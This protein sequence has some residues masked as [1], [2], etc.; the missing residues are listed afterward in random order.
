MNLLQI[1]NRPP[2]VARTKY[3]RK[4]TLKLFFNLFALG[5]VIVSIAAA[6]SYITPTLEGYGIPANIAP[7]IGY[8]IG[9]ILDFTILALAASLVTDFNLSRTVGQSREVDAPTLI[10]FLSMFA[11][12]IYFAAIGIDNR[13]TAAQIER[14]KAKQTTTVE[15]PKLSN[16]ATDKEQRKAAQA[17]ATLATIAAK[18]DSTKNANL[19]KLTALESEQGSNSKLVSI[20]LFAVAVFL[21]MC[22]AYFDTFYSEVEQLNPSPTQPNPK[23]TDSSNYVETKAQIIATPTGHRAPESQAELQ[24]KIK[25]L[26]EAAAKAAQ[27]YRETADETTAADAL[28]RYETITAELIALGQPAPKNDLKRLQKPKN[29]K[30]GF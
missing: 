10:A 28:S 6:Q 22:S 29:G 1:F 25:N 15:P 8:L 5:C 9:A 14:E 3:E 26:R 19:D 17:A 13:T 2:K 18:Q 30:I 12:Y 20:L 11:V 7:Y 23:A 21:R 27:T 24:L 4:K 16:T